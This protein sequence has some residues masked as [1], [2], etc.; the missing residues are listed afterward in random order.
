MIVVADWVLPVGEPPLRE[1]AVVV[2]EGAIADVGPAA[3]IAARWPDETET[4]ELPG[5]ILA[6]GLVNAHTHLALTVLEGLAPPAP[7]PDW[8][9]G[10]TKAVVGLSGPEFAA[11]SARGALECLRGG[12]TVVA[13]IVYGVESARAA[14]EVG[15][16]GAFCWE[17]LGM[18]AGDMRE[19]LDRRGFPPP[20]D[21]HAL[22]PED[23]VEPGV[24]PH[25][26][27]TAGPELL[28]AGHEFARR[29]GAPYVI[30][31]A[32]SLAEVTALAQG[33]GPLA[34]TARRLA[35]GFES[36]GVSPVAYLDGLGVLD[37]AVCVHVVH[38]DDHD[39][40]TLAR[41]ARGAVLCPRSNEWLGN[42]APPVAKLRA[43]GVRLAIGTDSAASNSDLDL[44]AEM[45]ELRALDPTI[46]AQEAL[47]MMT[48]AG[49]Q[50]LGMAGSLGTIAAG[51][52][53]DLV[54]VLADVAEAADPTAA[55]LE[56]GSAA[57]VDAVMAAG[58]WVVRDAEPVRDTRALREAAALAAEH[59]AQL[60]G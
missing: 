26:P 1:G 17:V 14:I 46:P 6:P 45:R 35:H 12:V 11:S 5:R 52:Q 53:A 38:V 3:D 41:A 4:V 39:I 56:Y 25:T 18:P 49:A 43:A 29:H 33:A 28:R 31:V 7:M 19:S 20:G 27:Y 50:L 48:A 21:E 36:P 23:R 15:L 10:V 57:T 24:S 30:H 34:A 60:M 44:F 22:G 54:A 32:E 42:G 9:Q 55:F 13:D 2:C 47:W 51:T 58:E 40:A 37:D 16:G 8:L 59:A